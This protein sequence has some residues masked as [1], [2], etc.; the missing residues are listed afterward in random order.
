MV[1]N[2]EKLKKIAPWWPPTQKNFENFS[3]SFWSLESSETW[4][5]LKK[6]IFSIQCFFID[7]A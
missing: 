6:I 2:G 3:K 1:W 5:K 4:K 7:R